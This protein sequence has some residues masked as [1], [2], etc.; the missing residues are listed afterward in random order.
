MEKRARLRLIVAAV[1]AAIV[2]GVVIWYALH[3]GLENTDDAQLETE[4]VP[5]PARTG[6]V[7]KSVQFVENQ[8]V[9]AG[10]VLAEL[11]PAL[12]EAR[13][14]QADA[15]LASAKENAA[16]AEAEVAVVEASAKGQHAAASAG[17]QTTRAGLEMSGEEI[18]QARAAVDAATAA[19][20]QAQLELERTKKLFEERAVPQQRMDA[21]QAGFDGAEANLQ[22]AKARFDAATASRASA[23]SRINE[24]EARV[25]QSS[26]VEAQIAQAR[27]R[28]GLARARV[29]AAQAARDLAALD[30]SYT[31]IA[32]PR[33]GIAAKKTVSVGQML[34]PGQPVCMLVA[35]DNVWVVANFKE[36][37]IARMRPGQPA[38]IS[39]D[40]YG[41][42]LEGKVESISGGT[43]ARFS[44]L[45]PEN[46]TG[47]FTKVV[48]RVPVRIQILNRPADKAL[49][50]GMSVDVTV[51]VRH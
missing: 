30:L 48:Q 20:R 32:A 43:G 23:A 17:L 24:A 14:A 31:K 13:L 12:H 45:P 33:D 47:N 49:L 5:L 34:Q 18:Q 9:K 11:D 7:V 36:T 29:A 35:T 46:A 42:K 38:D 15:E 27:A 39:V 19:R 1:L 8:P 16:A 51:D 4:V 2:G 6:G 37:Q 50:A 26:T 10:Q 40:A 21:A 3:A 41:I 44:L 22:Q 25:G 28:S